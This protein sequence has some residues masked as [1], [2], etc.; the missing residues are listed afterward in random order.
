MKKV[1]IFLIFLFE[2]SLAYSQNSITGTFPLLANQQV[3]LEG[4]NGFKNYTIANGNISEDGTFELEYS[5]ADYGMGFLMAEDNSSL[6]VVLTGRN[7]VF[8]GGNFS[9]QKTIEIIKGQENCLFAQYASEH[10]RRE[11]AL[12]AWM[13]L[14]KI[15]SRDLLFAVQEVPIQAI[16]KEKQRIKAEDSLFLSVLDPETYVS[17]YFPVRKLVSSVSTVVQYRT[18]E[19][20]ATI[21]AFR[22]LD[23]TDERLYKSGLLKEA[24][25]SHFW[26]IE[27]SGGS[28]DS[29]YAK[30]KV[31]IDHLVENLTRDEKKL[32]EITDYLFN[33]LERHSLFE[34]S[35]YLALKVLNEEG[36][37]LDNDLARQLESYRSMKKGNTAPDFT[38]N[39]DTY[40]PNYS[41]ANI[42]QKL[43]GI[44][45]DYTL[46]VFGASWCPKCTEELT[47]I[48][49]LYP[50]WKS[51]GVE[52]VFVSLDEEKQA[53]Q[54]FVANFPFISTCDYQKWD[55][56]VVDDYYV[57]ATPTM[58]LLDHEREIL[59]RPNS[60]KQMDAWVDWFLVDGR[61]N[62]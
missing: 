57:F 7:I 19:I 26:L 38:F 24:V 43:S 53:H 12:S 22:E 47:K 33:L 28:L 52:V 42:P 5:D 2:C 35:E 36:C 32:N 50:N 55:S 27:N 14:E 40:A 56:P 11:Q 1:V 10:P 58:Y 31:S 30:M 6:L 15:Y 20:P 9:N 16:A 48:S 25:E 3:K 4:F 21:A 45:S 54:K 46:V 39:G 17:W 13:Y 49:E 59:L 61:I 23:Y 8:K 44:Q 29:V 41:S 18:E 51:Q 60:V 34:A 62:Q 37:T